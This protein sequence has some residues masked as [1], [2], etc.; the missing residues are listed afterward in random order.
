MFC[1]NFYEGSFPNS[2]A[3]GSSPLLT[4]DGARFQP[5][6]FSL[7]K[8]QVL[9]RYPRV[10]I[11]LLPLCLFLLPIFFSV[12]LKATFRKTLASKNKLLGIYEINYHY[13]FN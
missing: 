4:F 6:I 2:S 8:V 11:S 13:F 7:G 10:E 1:K 9:A 3:D 5:D 12:S